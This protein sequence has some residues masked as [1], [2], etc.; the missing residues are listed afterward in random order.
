MDKLLKDPVYGYISID[1]NIMDR[2]VDDSAFQRLRHI[3][4]TSYTPLYSSALHNS[5]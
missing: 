5:L 1:K 3:G 4:Q 2:I